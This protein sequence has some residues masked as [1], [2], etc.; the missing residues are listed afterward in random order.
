MEGWMAEMIVSNRKD[1]IRESGREDSR[2]GAGLVTQKMDV[3]GPSVCGL[4]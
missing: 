1:K 2:E 4:N 3:S